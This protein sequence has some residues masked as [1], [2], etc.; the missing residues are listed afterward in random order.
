MREILSSILKIQSGRQIK[1]SDNSR[2][3]GT[4]YPVPYLLRGNVF[5]KYSRLEIKDTQIA[6]R[7]Y[8]VFEGTEI[9]FAG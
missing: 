9:H 5:L 1:E 4:Y 6:A 3:Q 7:N 8:Y 2:G